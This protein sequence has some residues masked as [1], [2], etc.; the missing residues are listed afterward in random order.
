LTGAWLYLAI[1]IMIALLGV[2]ILL[3][4]RSNKVMMAE[5]EGQPGAAASI[6][7][8]MRGD[9]RV[10]PAVSSTTQFDLVHLVVGRPGVILLG[11]GNPQR[12]R[13]LIGQEK[14]RLSKVI[15]TAPLYDYM[16]GTGDD[17]LSIRKMRGT[18]MRLPRNLTGKDVN[19]LDKRLTALSTRPRMPQGAIP[20]DMR[21]PKGAFRQMRGR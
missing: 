5:A 17:E 11:E 15:G 14:R 9:W 3:N 18:L 19:A 1:A 20:K 13:Q 8:T 12:V 16:I 6:V 21:P 7:E 4:L 10:T 2:M